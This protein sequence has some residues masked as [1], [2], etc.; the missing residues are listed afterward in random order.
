MT[1]SR[2]F[3]I[4]YSACWALVLGVVGVSAVG[5]AQTSCYETKREA[6]DSVNPDSLIVPASRSGRYRVVSIQSD[7]VLGHSWA[8][9]AD[10]KHPEWPVSAFQITESRS[11]LPLK[12]RQKPR[13]DTR[14]GPVVRAGDTVRLWK[15][16]NLLRI[17]IAGTSEESGDLGKTIRVRLLRH[18]TDDQSIQEQFSGIVRGP[19]DVEMRP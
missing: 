13:S 2:H 10:C 18:D 12:I 3:R 4:R 19:S 11:V 1:R 7:P 16:E 5:S 17:E 6:I 8:L 14:T 15:Q 9:I